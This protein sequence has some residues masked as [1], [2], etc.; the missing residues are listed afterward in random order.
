MSWIAVDRDGSEYV[1]EIPPMLHR[2]VDMWEVAGDCVEVPKGTAEK[3][4]GS[5]M[6]WDDEPRELK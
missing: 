5:P 3:L 1:Y 6:G 2:G 4:T